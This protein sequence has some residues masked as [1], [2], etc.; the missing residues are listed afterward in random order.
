M[1]VKPIYLDYNATTPIHPEAAE[2]ML[3]Y[4]QEHFGNP[5]SA[6]AYGY[7]TKQA[8]ENARFQ[9]ASLLNCSPSEV[10][11]T[12]GG[13]ESNNLAIQ[14]IALRQKSRGNHIITS[15]IEHP[16]VIEVCKWLELQGFRTT[17]LPV[18][19][20]GFV[21]PKD[22]KNQITDETILVSIMLANNE[23][24]SIQPVAE[25][26]EIAHSM[27]IT[28]H[29]DAAQAIGKI[30]VDVEELGVDLLSVAGHKFY[31]P[32]GIGA[33]YVRSGTELQKFIHGASQENN[34][35][36]GTENVLE[37]VGFGKAA[38]VAKRDLES[39]NK[40]LRGMKT[41]LQENLIDH[42]GEAIVRVNSP[43]HDCLPNTFNVSFRG[44]KANVLLSEISHSVA[45]SAG[46]ACHSDQVKLSSVIEA[47]GIPMV[48]AKGTIRFSTGI[49]TTEDGIN[50]AVSTIVDAIRKFGS[51]AKRNIVP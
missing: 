20:H 44:F 36:P 7:R 35:R 25:L 40:H 14:G 45:A 16:A 24:G 34:W 19:S 29:T 9:L 3:P 30:T 8:V 17:H 33:L 38:E 15:Q 37:I 39:N 42:L 13:T 12:S 32:K 46:A 6:H 43:Q 51:E 18:D 21:N 50:Q 4:L 27:G 22:L 5:S 2:A 49:N 23:V 10:V 47:M 1:T 28:F 41:L 26:S 11:F 48:W 31:A